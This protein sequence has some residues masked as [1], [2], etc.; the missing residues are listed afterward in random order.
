MSFAETGLREWVQLNCGARFVMVVP[1]A[2]IESV[3]CADIAT[4]TVLSRRKEV[5][6]ARNIANPPPILST[7]DKQFAGPFPI[8]QKESYDGNWN[9]DFFSE[10]DRTY[11]LASLKLTSEVM[12][13]LIF[14]DAPYPWSSDTERLLH[15]AGLP[16]SVALCYQRRLQ[17]I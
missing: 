3:W 10:K 5:S 15:A 12:F 16:L 13:D 17:R 6:Q 1:N 14:T 2:G 8:F 7:A 9:P 4:H 11:L